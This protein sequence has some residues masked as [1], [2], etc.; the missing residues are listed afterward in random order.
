MLE[1]V[2][3]RASRVVQGHDF[4]IDNRFRR[5][6]GEG[7]GDVWVSL[8]KVFAVA[9]IQDGVAAGFDSDD[10]IAVELNFV[11]PLWSF[12]KLRDKGTFLWFDE[13]G[14]SFRKRVQTCCPATQ[15]ALR[16]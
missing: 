1:R 8:I 3:V 10:A 6:L 9:R 11:G 4:T 7:F 16:L 14:F 5:K 15:H 2:K 12:G 13:F